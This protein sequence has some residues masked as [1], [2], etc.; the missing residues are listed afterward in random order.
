MDKLYNLEKSPLYNLH[1]R[2][3]L[4]KLVGNVSYKRITEISENTTPFYRCFQQVSKKGKVR[5]VSQCIGDLAPIQDRLQALLRRIE[6]PDYLF[7][8]RL[9]S[10]KKNAEFH[11]GNG[12]AFTID[13]KNFYPSCTV[14]R[15]ASSLHY[16]FKQEGDIARLIA[17]LM[18]LNGR[19]P[20]GSTT[21]SIAAF[22]TNKSM[23]DEIFSLCSLNGL[24][25]SVF[26]DDL[27]ISSSL[28]IERDIIDRVINIIR[29]NGMPVNYKKIKSF[30]PHQHIH[31][32]GLAVQG[33]L[34][35][36]E[37]SKFKKLFKELMDKN[38]EQQKIKGLYR[39]IKTID[40]S[41]KIPS[42]E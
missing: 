13:L 36:V 8:K 7:S 28:P 16:H 33:N 11:R 6:L 5:D 34:V 31:I 22:I 15:L 23:F 25:F 10:P 26:V 21:S 1:S 4:L 9:S 18:T 39:Y 12:Y 29:K 3:Q 30:K 2:K 42:L 19:I 14:D 38:Q 27:T 24:R 17:K 37:N 41:F 35:K 40:N 20:Q 32:T